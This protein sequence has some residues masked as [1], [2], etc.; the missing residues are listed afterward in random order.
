VTGSFISKLILAYGL[1]IA[2]MLEAEGTFDLLVNL[3]QT[4]RHNNPEDSHLKTRS[5]L[6]RWEIMKNNLTP[7]TGNFNTKSGNMS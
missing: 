7:A 4:T 6:R 5:G 1:V 2:L 3:Y